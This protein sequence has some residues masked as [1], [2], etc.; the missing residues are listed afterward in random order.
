MVKECG[1]SL[2]EII[3]VVIAMPLS[4]VVGGCLFVAPAADAATASPP[5][6]A[7]ALPWMPTAM[8]LAVVPALA[9]LT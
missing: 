2:T 9:I 1:S 8:I 4:T 3:S 7:A 6:C 5:N